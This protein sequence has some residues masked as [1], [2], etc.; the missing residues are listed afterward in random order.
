MIKMAIN[1]DRKVLPR[2]ADGHH[3]V[4]LDDYKVVNNDR[5]GYI[6]LVLKFADRNMQW[7]VFPTQIDYVA[8]ML[9]AQFGLQEQ[10]TTLGE[11]LELAKTTVFDIWTEVDPQYGRNY[12]LSK[13]AEVINPDT[14]TF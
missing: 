1:L 2:L 10:E 4:L 12:S 6:S 11:L 7:V 5:G 14:V 3:E 13:P 8:G 9:Q